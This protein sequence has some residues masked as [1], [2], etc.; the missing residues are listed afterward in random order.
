MDFFARQDSARRRT[1]L[2]VFLYII[3]VALVIVAVY[4]AF[5]LV[6]IG[7]AAGRSRTGG[8]DWNG[9]W[10]PEVFAWVAGVTVGVVLLGTLWKMAQLRHGGRAVAAILGGRPVLR[11]TRDLAERR[12]LNV[13]EEIAIA[14]GTSVP[15]VFVL[16]KEK[17]INA[18]AAGFTPSDAVIG[19]TRG[20]VEKLSRDEL[21]GVIAHEFSHILNGDMRLNL[22]LIG[23]LN[24]IL[25]LALTGYVV[26]RITPHMLRGMGR[27]ARGKG[28]A[29]VLG[30]VVALAIFGVL[31]LVI[32]YVGVFVGKII[33]S[34][35]S[36][37]REFLAD[38][39]AV[40][41]TRQPSGL[42]GALKKIGGTGYGSRVRSPRAEE[43]SH[44]F[45]AN[46][47]RGSITGLTATHP[48]T[49]ERI[50]RM[51][52]GFDGDF[53]PFAAAARR[54]EAPAPAAA[55]AKAGK[56]LLDPLSVE[57]GVLVGTVLATRALRYRADPD[58]VAASVGS[59]APEHL[60][61]ASRLIASLPKKLAGGTKDPFGVRAVVYCLLLNSEAVPRRRQLERLEQHADEA[62][63]EETLRLVPE[64]ERLGPGARLPL[65]DMAIPTLGELSAEHYRAFVENM[66][67]LIRAD[68]RVDVFEYVV[69]RTI[70]HRL[71]PAFGKAKP[72]AARY[73]AIK[74][75]AG[76][77]VDLLA[78]L[79]YR[80]AAG[81]G[82]AQQAFAR[83]IVRAGVKRMPV[84]PPA[85]SCGLKKLD[86][87]LKKLA[88]AS[89]A[90]KKRVIKACTACVAAD[91]VVTVDE[92][93]LLRAVAVL[94]DCPVPPFLP[95][96]RMQARPA[97]AGAGYGS[98]RRPDSN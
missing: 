26:L 23:V 68:E 3:A 51:E 77:C 56:R 70:T 2:L 87:A 35:V 85:E 97:S 76:T 5:A 47:L 81:A 43:A 66:N 6:F 22:R 88:L 53:A 61:Y 10:D 44:L 30:A 8:A 59:P 74:P 28:G 71:A 60:A 95:G 82:D 80:G 9:L 34:A 1:S 90:I 29:A 63:Y 96:Q 41:F 58:E 4:F 48:S 19:V 45:F 84:M 25:V 65:L 17:G 67:H 13:I 62:V 21:Q 83:G 57:G 89:P 27:G 16:D 18:F 11:S 38:A 31:L 86:D 15:P 79:A 93:E 36:R 39:A 55:R 75:L 32:G 37:Q 7:I 92:A 40:E 54:E 78:C 69:S 42:A 52:P 91:G 12:L 24:G 20:C 98:A 49:L 33:K 94:L 50:R 73:Y 14:S 46:G 72:P 64:A